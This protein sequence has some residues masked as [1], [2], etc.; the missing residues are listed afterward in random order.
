MTL[1]HVWAICNFSVL[2]VTSVHDGHVTTRLH[3]PQRG[4]ITHSQLSSILL[5]HETQS[6]TSSITRVPP[7]IRCRLVS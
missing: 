6:L 5:C 4:T 7:G 3:N 1:N 2:Q